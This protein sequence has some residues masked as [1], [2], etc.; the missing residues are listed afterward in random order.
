MAEVIGTARRQRDGLLYS[1][2]AVNRLPFGI[3]VTQGSLSNNRLK[4]TARGR[5]V[6]AWR[7]RARAAA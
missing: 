1:W 7:L 5:P 6:G 4:L 2:L 3:A